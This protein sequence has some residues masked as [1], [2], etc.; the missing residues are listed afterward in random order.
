[1]EKGEKLN[2]V[3]LHSITTPSSDIKPWEGSIWQ[4]F[5]IYIGEAIEGEIFKLIL[6]DLHDRHA[7]QRGIWLPT[8]HL[9]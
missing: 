1:V 5:D 3:P 7:V 2:R 9:L 8:Q 6:G 4:N